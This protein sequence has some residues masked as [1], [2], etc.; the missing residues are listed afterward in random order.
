MRKLKEIIHTKGRTQI[1]Y[2]RLLKMDQPTFSKILNGGYGRRFTKEKKKI[3]KD[4]L[5]NEDKVDKKLVQ[6]AL[7]ELEN[8]INTRWTVYTV[9]KERPS[10][11]RS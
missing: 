8:R 6:S 11:G 5:V 7:E 4:F 3:L 9:P 10:M 2:C 1:F